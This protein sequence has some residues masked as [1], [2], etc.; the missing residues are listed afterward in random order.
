MQRRSSEL[1]QGTRTK[2]CRS[3]SLGQAAKTGQRQQHTKRASVVPKLPP[4]P[5]NN[6]SGEKTKPR[7]YIFLLKESVLLKHRKKLSICRANPLSSWE[8]VERLWPLVTGGCPEQQRQK[9]RRNISLGSKSSGCYSN[10]G[11]G[12][13]LGFFF[14][15]QFLGSH[16]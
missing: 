2:W 1:S 14:F 12:R 4:S 16:G 5:S 9:V 3:H 7:K 10:R 11:K 8:L 13:Y 15:N 6:G